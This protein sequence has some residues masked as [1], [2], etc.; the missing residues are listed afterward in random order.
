[1]RSNAKT[2]TWKKNKEQ[3]K[4]NTQRK[5]TKD[6]KSLLMKIAVNGTILPPSPS[7]SSSIKSTSWPLT[8]SKPAR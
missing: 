2:I 7:P 3:K 8:P 6:K 4:Q 1:M 5:E